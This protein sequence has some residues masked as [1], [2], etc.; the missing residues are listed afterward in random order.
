MSPVQSENR[1]A[2]GR[3]NHIGVAS[4]VPALFPCLDLQ[5]MNGFRRFESGSYDF[6]MGDPSLFAAGACRCP[7][8]IEY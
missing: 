6:P 8:I 5:F 4:D 3:A 2:D 1:Q 7:Q